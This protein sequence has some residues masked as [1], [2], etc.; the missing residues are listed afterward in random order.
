[1]YDVNGALATFQL[2]DSN[3]NLKTTM[4][5]TDIVG[6]AGNSGKEGWF[7]IDVSKFDV[8]WNPGDIIFVEIT[9]GNYT[10]NATVNLTTAGTDQV[11]FSTCLGPPCECNPWRQAQEDEAEACASGEALFRVCHPRKCDV[12]LQCT[13]AEKNCSCT[14]WS[15]KICDF[16]NP[17]CPGMTYRYR[18]C[19]PSKCDIEEECMPCERCKC[20]NNLCQEECNETQQNCPQDCKVELCGDGKCQTDKGENQKT[21]PKDCGVYNP[22]WS[23]CGNKICEPQLQET[24][25]SCPVD[26][27]VVTSLALTCDNGVCEP[28][29]GENRENCCLDCGC[30]K[31]EECKAVYTIKMKKFKI[32]RIFE[33]Y[34]CK[35]VCCLTIGKFSYCKKLLIC[36]YYWLLIAVLAALAIILLKKWRRKSKVV[37]KKKLK[38]KQQAKAVKRVKKK[39]KK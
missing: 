7:A 16:E 27:Y 25:E 20:G 18:S 26:C 34:K 19:T 28:E 12:E 24:K 33:G 37:K 22:K 15:Y 1:M 31:G 4:N 35:K 11:F 13:S 30:P 14:D 2:A 29:L 5:L 17:K 36:W 23:N 32:E 10:I 3:G 8:D 38:K 6:S 21:C 39:R 9:K